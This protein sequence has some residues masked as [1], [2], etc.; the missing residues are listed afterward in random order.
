MRLVWI[1]I[2]VRFRY[3]PVLPA[4]MLPARRGSIS[5]STGGYCAHTAM[6]RTAMPE[7][8]EIFFALA[9]GWRSDDSGRKYRGRKRQ[10]KAQPRGVALRFHQRRRFWRICADTCKDAQRDTIMSANRSQCKHFLLLCNKYCGNLII[11]NKYNYLKIIRN[12][13]KAQILS[14]LMHKHLTHDHDRDLGVEQYFA[15]LTAQQSGSNPL[16]AM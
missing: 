6:A 10:K 3:V 14:S 16:A 15:R 5:E 13:E 2:A 7:E 12:S 9:R 4:A 8:S 1:A 11:L